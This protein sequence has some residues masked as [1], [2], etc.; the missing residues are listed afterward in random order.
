MADLIIVTGGS[1]SGKTSLI[2]ELAARGCEVLPESAFEVIS[3]LNRIHGIERQMA[4]RQTN[5]TAFQRRVTERQHAREAVARRSAARFV[6]CDRGLL[7]GMAYCR[8]AGAEWPDDLH[9]LAAP[10][11]YAHAFVLATLGTFDPRYDTG[12]IHTRDD[13]IR[14]AS[15]LADIYRAQAEAVTH[16]PDTPLAERADLVLRTLGLGG[17]AATGHREE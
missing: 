3:E 10:A 16:V 8:L 15:L 6:F 13:S 14:V 7:D 17:E 9:A 4:W 5:L 12:R 11:R 1:Y 2:R